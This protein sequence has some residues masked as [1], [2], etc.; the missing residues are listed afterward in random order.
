V[1]DCPRD[2]AT[3]TIDVLVIRDITLHHDSSRTLEVRSADRGALLWSLRDVTNGG[4]SSDGSYLW[5]VSATSLRVF[6]HDGHERFSLAGNY[7]QAQ[8]YASSDAIRV[9]GGPSSG[10]LQTIRLADHNSAYASVQ[11]N[12]ASWFSDGTAFVT[13]L[14]ATTWVYTNEGIQL[15]IG[16]LPD[17][18]GLGGAGGYV[19][20]LNEGRFNAP[21]RLYAATDLSAPIQ[22]FNSELAGFRISGSRI[23]ALRQ[24]SL[25]IISVGASVAVGDAIPIA[26][27]SVVAFSSDAEGD[28]VIGSADGVVADD[29]AE[30][31]G[32]NDTYSLGR[33]LS[34]A[35]SGNAQAA[36]A[37]A[38]DRV[39]MLSVG[40]SAAPIR[41]I[42]VPHSQIALS[43]DGSI[44]VAA[45]NLDSSQIGSD[46][47]LRT[48]STTDGSVIHTW[49]YTLP[50][51]GS[52]LLGFTFAPKG[53]VLSQLVGPCPAHG[54]ED[55]VR[56]FTDVTGATFP[57][58]GPPLEAADELTSQL[59]RLSPSGANA[60]F[61]S[62]GPGIGSAV[63]L[64]YSNSSLVTAIP[65]V[66]LAWLDD[67]HILVATYHLERQGMFEVA[68]QDIVRIY[69]ARGHVTS[70]A[71]LPDVQSAQLVPVGPVSGTF[72]Y[73][74]LHNQVLDYTT[75]AVYW[76]GDP[77]VRDAVP[78]G[79]YVLYTR[80]ERIFVDRFRRPGS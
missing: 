28:W 13:T 62:I 15:A 25:Q 7:S 3:L 10:A 9:L 8:I 18:V 61:G 79:D 51:S 20:E 34:L 38:S 77:D 5:A 67:A 46:R 23:A 78:V 40:P 56:L 33:A 45:E 69:D 29:V 44:L 50:L 63:T 54:C 66:A 27:T 58:Y 12:F 17:V 76:K 4:V 36:I 32:S 59:P 71:Q 19:W 57:N 2:F 53:L 11:G 22:T 70:T 1:S 26:M 31:S 30:R 55:P 72:V 65:G 35:S 42:Q 14:G 60:V 49:P 47:S 48:F 80:N 41:T 39:I 37:T 64:I 21:L 74:P 52:T 24:G 73:W 16:I 43:D 75:G 68:V 6:S